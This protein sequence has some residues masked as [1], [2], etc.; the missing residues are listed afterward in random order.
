MNRGLQLPLRHTR[1]QRNTTGAREGPH[2]PHRLHVTDLNSLKAPVSAAH[3]PRAIACCRCW[4]CAVLSLLQSSRTH[5][6]A[7]PAKAHTCSRHNISPH[8]SSDVVEVGGAPPHSS[9]GRQGP[10]GQ[11]RG[12]RVTGFWEENLQGG[13]TGNKQH[14]TFH[15]T[16]AQ[17][18]QGWS[19]H[20][21]EHVSPPPQ[22][23]HPTGHAST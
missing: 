9:G 7:R 14:N 18:K 3:A 13:G 15:V 23:G 21:A 19:R 2:H 6:N 8:R 17:R 5:G 10:Y 11:G 12:P 16:K 22:A 4:C 20:G 1:S